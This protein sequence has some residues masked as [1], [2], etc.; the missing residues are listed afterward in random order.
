MPHIIV[1]HSAHLDFETQELLKDLHHDLASRETVSIGGIK[2]RAIS[3][4][5]ACVGEDAAAD[6]FAHITLKLLPGRSDALRQEMAQGLFD[7][8]KK[9]IID[10]NTAITVETAELHQSSYIK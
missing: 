9:H 2:T 6:S 7:A 5:S 3:I 10:P 8:A 1:E 4:E